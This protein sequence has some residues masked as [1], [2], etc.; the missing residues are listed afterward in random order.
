MRFVK[1]EIVLKVTLPVTY[2]MYCRRQDRCIQ[3]V[4]GCSRKYGFVWEQRISIRRSITGDPA[5]VCVSRALPLSVCL[6]I[7]RCVLDLKIRCSMTSAREESPYSPLLGDRA[8]RQLLY[9]SRL[10]VSKL[11]G[12]GLSPFSSEYLF[13]CEISEI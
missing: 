12:G 9:R 5:G 3:E 6:P 1:F 8:F 11:R 10:R 2:F 13:S 4:T 7:A